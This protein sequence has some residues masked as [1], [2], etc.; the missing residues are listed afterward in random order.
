MTGGVYL[1]ASGNEPHTAPALEFTALRAAL[2]LPTSS[3]SGIE[4]GEYQY[5]NVPQLLTDDSDKIANEALETE[6]ANNCA[7]LSS[8]SG[9]LWRMPCAF[10]G[11][12]YASMKIGV[13]TA[14]CKGRN[15]DDSTTTI[16]LM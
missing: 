10:L 4:S 16:Q 9:R 11:K 14:L 12:A 15:V 6:G 1:A 7:L 13:G 3:H 5:L 2:G 8:S